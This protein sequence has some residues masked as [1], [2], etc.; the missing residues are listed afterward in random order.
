MTVEELKKAI[1]EQKEDIEERKKHLEFLENALENEKK[2]VEDIPLVYPTKD[3]MRIDD[4]GETYGVL[5]YVCGDGRVLCAENDWSP[6]L[7]KLSQ[8]KNR[9]FPSKKYADMFRDK[10]QFITYCLLF[11]Y[12]YDRDYKP[13]WKNVEESKCFVSF[14]YEED[15]YLRNTTLF[16]DNNAV[17]FSSAEI[18]DKCADW[19]NYLYK[20]GKY[21]EVEYV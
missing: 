8:F 1:A 15:A 6:F 5:Y 12:L 10:S 14:N 9:A 11:K 17:Y 21:G 7:K 18:A 20:K 4:C 3:F 16:N 19:L 13:D 2:A